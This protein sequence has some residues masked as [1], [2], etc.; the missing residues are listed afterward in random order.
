MCG[1]LTM[2]TVRGASPG[3]PRVML[4]DKQL[5]QK[6]VFDSYTDIQASV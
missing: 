5:M 1:R 4:G 3:A 2:R 6:H